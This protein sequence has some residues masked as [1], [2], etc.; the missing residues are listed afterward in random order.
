MSRRYVKEN[1]VE[2]AILD[3]QDLEYCFHTTDGLVHATNGVSFQLRQGEALAIVG[4]SGCGKSVTMMSILRLIPEPPGEIVNGKALFHDRDLLTMEPRE[5]RS[6]RG[7]RIG[8]IFQ[9]PMTALNPSMSIGFQVIEGL[10]EH[11]DMD[12]K[13]AH[14]EAIRL[15]TKVGISNPGDRFDDFPHQF[16][17]GMRQRVMIA[18]ALAC[19]PEVLIA[20]E[21]TTALDVTIQAQI[22]DLVLELRKEMGM[23]IIW[24]THDLSVIARMAD[25]VAVMYA[26]RLV[27]KTPI[28]QLYKNPRHPYTIGLL[29]A[30]PRLD[31]GSKK[32]LV[33]I[34]G[35]PPHMLKKPDSCS[36]A[37]RCPYAQARCWN[38]LPT[39]RE[40][41]DD[42]TTACFFDVDRDLD[43]WR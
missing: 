43:I 8:M 6:I 5:I 38:E 24:I 26:G 7:M 41:G 10:L 11:N 33:N 28:S 1:A 30:L 2:G 40:V 42:H 17:G 12:R 31:F 27:E 16:S 19:H 21:P 15:L 37:P 29:G 20:D 9:D 3:V 32:R 35:A 4:E 39:L 36:F 25:N 13:R 34:Q 18:I 14:A 23:A 22:V